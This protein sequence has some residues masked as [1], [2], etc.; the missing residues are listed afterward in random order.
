MQTVVLL[1]Q[2]DHDHA[3]FGLVLLIAAGSG[4]HLLTLRGLQVLHITFESA[5]TFSLCVF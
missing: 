3:V 4:R 2:A 1:E 5:I